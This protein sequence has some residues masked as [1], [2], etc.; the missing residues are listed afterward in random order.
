MT[1]TAVVVG[2]GPNGLAA[3]IALA[4]GDVDVH[5]VEAA[6]T[7]G[8]GA[9]TTEYLAPGLLHDDCAAFHPTGAASP[10]FRELD[11]EFDLAAHGLEWAYPE[12]DLAHPLDHGDAALLYRDLDR[13]CDGLG[14]DGGRWRRVFGPLARNFDALAD[15]VLAPIVGVPRHPLLL[16]RFGVAAALPA[17]VLARTWRT[18]AA[19]AL[20]GG[21]AAHKFGSLRGPLTSAVGMLLTTAAHAQ[22]WPVARGGTHAITR[23]LASILT[24]LGGTIETGRTVETLGDAVRPGDGRPDAVL[25][26]VTP[27]GAHRILGDALP[28]RIARAYRHYRFGPAAFKVDFAVRGTA[29]GDVVPWA[30]PAVRRAGTIHLGG[31]LDEIAAAEDA[32]VR[33]AM[34]EAPFVLVGQQFVSDPS[35]SA[36]DLHPLWAYAH[37]PHAFPGDVTEAV[38]AQIERFAPGF[39]DRV[40]ATHVRSAPEMQAYNL[41]NVGGDV[42]GGAN[43]AW[44]FVARPRLSPAPYRTGVPGVYLC[45]S[46][47]PPGGGVHGMCGF[48]AARTALADGSRSGSR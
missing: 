41:N 27:S 21:V 12:I 30:N 43:T 3:A 32:T 16:A 15:D 25:L 10:W 8:G 11:R 13:T 35:R 18:P 19:R 26:D 9:R 44:Q 40:V 38:A 48:H 42:V 33:G 46:S 14:V 17:T 7:I 22:G 47:T 29:P 5:V 4:R 45:S 1:R 6:D 34:P 31:T 28:R 37:V 20:F 36:G 2:S 23:A 24:E 39:R